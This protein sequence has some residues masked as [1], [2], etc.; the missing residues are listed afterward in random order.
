MVST[1]ARQISLST[2]PARREDRR[3]AVVVVVLSAAVFLALAPFATVQ[4]PA[5]FAFIPIYEAALV[6]NDLIT[7]I[8][9]LG[10]VNILRSRALLVLA[11]GYL[12]TA[13]MAAAHMLTFPGLFTPTGLLGAGPQTTAWIYMFWH[14]GFPL[15]VIAY[16]L[17]KN[18]GDA[19]ILR[20]RLAM[21]LA[22]VLVA[23]LVCA[24]TWLATG[25]EALLPPIMN[26]NLHTAEV[27]DAVVFSAW[28]ASPVALLVLWRRRPHSVL[29]TSLMVVLCAWLF[30]VALSAALNAGRFDLGFYAGRI[31][32]LMAASFVLLVL[33]LESGALYVRLA[34]SMEAERDQR[35]RRLQEAQTLLIHVSRISELSLMVPELAHEVNQ[36]LTA[37]GNYLDATQAFIRDGE[38]AKAESV[39]QKAAQQVDRAGEILRR[40]RNYVRRGESQARPERLAE[41]VEE[42]VALVF[43]DSS[44]RGVRSDV[45]I[46]PRVSTVLIDKIQIQQVL[47]NLIRNAFEAMSASSRRIVTI[48]A[49]PVEAGRVEISVADTGRGLSEEVRAKLFEPFVTTKAGGMGIGLSICRS[50]IESHGGALHAADN[51]GGGTVFRFTLPVARAQEQRA[52]S[53]AA[54]L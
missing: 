6:I 44:G 18:R 12:F 43:I 38:G 31:Y 1:S 53:D 46:D 34:Q 48:V 49:A 11:G 37:I 32:G 25:G 30:D 45:R 41:V 47:L 40:L 23:V 33:L 22:A 51:P 17:L 3:R 24:L 21:A 16:A 42:A 19:P 9:L 13:L 26:G 36:P 27:S 4:L 29:D 54:A 20:P 15:A 39:L 52:A 10:Q 35:E 14:A 50:I 8:L 7:A 2:L 28:A 5:V